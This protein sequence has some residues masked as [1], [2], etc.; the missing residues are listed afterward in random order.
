MLKIK[1]RVTLGIVAGILGN[2]VKQGLSF[3][4]KEL[5]LIKITAPDKAGGMFVS[6]RKVKKPMGSVL[7]IIADFCI[8]CKLSILLVYILSGTGKDNHILKG[9]SLGSSAWAI[10]YGFLSRIGGTGFNIIRPRDSLSGFVTHTV[11]GVAVAQLIVT[12]GD[13]SLFRPRYHSLSNP[14]EQEELLTY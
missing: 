2:L 10:M 4:F 7:G 12:L 6:K 3:L 8:A 11:F 5:G 9:L 14:D 1:D 13:D